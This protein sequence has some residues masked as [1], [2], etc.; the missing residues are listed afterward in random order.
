MGMK[1][2]Y[3]LV[4]A[5]ACLFF[6]GCTNSLKSRLNTATKIALNHAGYAAKLQRQECL[7]AGDADCPE[8]K[9]IEKWIEYGNRFLV[10]L[11]SEN[12]EEDPVLSLLDVVIAEMKEA[13]REDLVLYARDIQILLTEMKNERKPET[14]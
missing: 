12:F 1:R 14:E 11:N 6:A 4:C 7:E 5:A 10:Y 13:G 2:K 8:A 3:I 9:Q